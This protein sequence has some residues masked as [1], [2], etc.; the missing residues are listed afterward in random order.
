MFML[1]NI[2]FWIK[3]VGVRTPNLKKQGDFFD[4]SQT[5]K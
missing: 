4:Q 5:T 1:I 3:S 2:K